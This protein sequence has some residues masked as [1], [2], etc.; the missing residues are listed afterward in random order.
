MWT[1]LSSHAHSIVKVV[2]WE[3]LR[4]LCTSIHIYIRISL[5][6]LQYNYDKTTWKLIKIRKWY[7][8]LWCS[9]NI[10]YMYVHNENFWGRKLEV[11][12]LFAKVFYAEFGAYI[13]CWQQQTIDKILLHKNL[14]STNSWK[15]SPAKFPALQHVFGPNRYQHYQ[16]LCLENCWLLFTFCSVQTNL[17]T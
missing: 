11:L 6:T 8:K 9:E 4:M 10:A 17:F 15:F 14:F 12:W 7:S 3:R 13:F 16:T 2:Q 1:K 5:F